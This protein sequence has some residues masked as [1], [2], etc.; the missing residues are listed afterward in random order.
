MATRTRQLIGIVVGYLGLFVSAI[1]YGGNIETVAGWIPRNAVITVSIAQPGQ[2][3][4]QWQKSPLRQA[5][6]G[7]PAVREGLAN[8]R[9]RELEALVGMMELHTKQD[10]W[11]LAKTLIGGGL[12]AAALPDGQA[13]VVAEA[14]DA[15][16]LR[17]VHEF[18]V[19]LARLDAQNKGQ[20][21]RVRSADYRGVT[22]WTFGGDEA[23]AIIGNRLV[24]T[25]K[26]ELL[27]QIVDSSL[28]GPAGTLEENPK[29]A[30]ARKACEGYNLRAYVDLE[31]L[32][33]LP[34]VQKGLQQSREPLPILLLAG[35]VTALQQAP[36]LA[37]GLNI[38]GTKISGT[39]RTGKVSDWPKEL[40]FAIAAPN[41]GALAPLEVPNTLLSVT[42]YRNLR[43]FYAQKNELFPERT[44]G[45]IFFENMMGI[46][47]TGRN[48]TE[49]VLAELEPHVR[50]VVAGQRYSPE[51]GTPAI[52][53]P[54]F[55][56]AFRMKNPEKF[57]PIIEEGFQKALGLVNFIRGQDAQPGLLLDRPE[58]QGVKYTLAYFTPDPQADKN[59]VDIRFNFSPTLVCRD[60]DLVLS[61][62]ESLARDI[63][64]ALARQEA[65]VEAVQKS[66]TTHLRVLGSQI[67]QLLELN[68]EA[69]IAQNMAEKGHSREAAE[70]ELSQLLQLLRM[71]QSLELT[72]RFDGGMM[73]WDFHLNLNP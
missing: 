33:V 72:E 35:T 19:G 45:L 44:S 48:F 6:E 4:E 61:S 16:T 47:F 50:V 10:R 25:N 54:A 56:L 66:V 68:K 5:L 11:A 28:D 71:V 58:Y 65:A 32:R 9:L 42:F 41:Q 2:W 23:H 37:L 38:E 20:L 39:L 22:G 51:V 34:N 24:L 46:F 14:E 64:D 70:K 8:P 36:W 30:A 1:G 73:N 49:E 12:F 57:K 40:S 55:A 52:Q 59:R 63:L 27:K 18:L 69:L 62:A 43:D 31:A 21:G 26:A 15:E 29:Y 3:I 7:N 67:A 13:V 17:Q 60:R 53:L